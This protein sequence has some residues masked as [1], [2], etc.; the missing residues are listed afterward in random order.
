MPPSHTPISLSACLAVS[1]GSRV[2]FRLVCAGS[3]LVLGTPVLSNGSLPI[4]AATNSN[5][6]LAVIG[7][8]SCSQLDRCQFVRSITRQHKA[9]AEACWQKS[10]YRTT[11]AETAWIEISSAR[12]VSGTRLDRCLDKALDICNGRFF[13][14]QSPLSVSERKRFHFHLSGALLYPQYLIFRLCDQ[15]QTA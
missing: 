8:R 10:K 2:R 11:S 6:I 4:N 15:R 5:Q 3:R 12:T 14:R 7:S 13:F 9:Q 1:S